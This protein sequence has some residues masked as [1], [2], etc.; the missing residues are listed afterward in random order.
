MRVLFSSIGSVGH[1][2]PLVPLA[3][4]LVDAGHDVAI[5]T[6]ETMRASVVAAGFEHLAC[7]MSLETRLAQLRELVP[8][9]AA[10]PPARR[11][12]VMYGTNFATL[13]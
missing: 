13:A 1:L 2:F 8:D 9:Y 7:G 6:A 12:I 4:G 3:K 10:I 11:R 5:A